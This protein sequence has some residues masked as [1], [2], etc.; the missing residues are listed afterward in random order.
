MEGSEETAILPNETVI[1]QFQ[2][3]ATSDIVDGDPIP[4][5]PA[6]PAGAIGKYVVPGETIRDQLTYKATDSLV[7]ANENNGPDSNWINNTP[8]QFCVS[9]Y[10]PYDN[11]QGSIINL[12][13]AGNP[14]PIPP[15]TYNSGATVGYLDGASQT[16]PISSIPVNRNNSTA[17]QAQICH[18]A[19]RP[20][21]ATTL[22]PT[23][24][25]YDFVTTGWEPGYYYFVTEARKN[26]NPLII[27]EWVS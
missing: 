26:A 9:A 17:H 23:Y 5:D 12:P 6:N 13:T 16:A 3:Y 11:P 19:T 21:A 4:P 27:G 25:Q 10:G 18:D 8:V 22:E 20:G 14:A 2:P 1:R 7:H 15:A 24:G